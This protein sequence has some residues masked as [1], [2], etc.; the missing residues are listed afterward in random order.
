[1]SIT[2]IFMLT[3]LSTD[4]AL[5]TSDTQKLIQHL[6]KRNNELEVTESMI[7][8]ARSP[9]VMEVLLQHAPNMNVTPEMLS[10]AAPTEECEYVTRLRRQ[11]CVL[12]LLAHYSS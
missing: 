12:L 5:A 7:K 1:M 11:K 8:E 3:V 10:A 4:Y 6:F 9:E 2:P